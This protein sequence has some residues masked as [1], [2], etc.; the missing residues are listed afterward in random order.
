MLSINDNFYQT[1]HEEGNLFS[2]PGSLGLVEGYDP[3]TIKPLYVSQ[4]WKGASYNQKLAFANTNTHQESTKTVN[5]PGA[6]T[7]A[8]SFVDNVFGTDTAKL[9]ADS[10]SSFSRST[11]DEES[12]TVNIP[13][14]HTGS[15]FS[16]EFQPYVDIAGTTTVAFAV[17][18]FKTE[19]ALWNGGNA[20]HPGSLYGR[21]PDPSLLLPEKFNHVANTDPDHELYDIPQFVSNDND[22]TALKLRGF[23]FIADEYDQITNNL[24]VKGLKYRIRVPVFNAS[25]VSTP[26]DKP[27]VVRLSLA[28]DNFYNSPRT[29]ITDF[30]FKGV[31]PG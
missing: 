12:I 29:K 26:E 31:L 30:T 25:F 6:I 9:P 4:G 19:D 23:R 17:T 18:D 21:K 28:K 20:E 27:L 10:F 14:A 24:L 22:P 5:K 13:T 1:Y 11:T 15:Q 16:L 8:L 2:Y 7:K 3:N